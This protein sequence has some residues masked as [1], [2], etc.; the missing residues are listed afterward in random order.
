MRI[1]DIEYT[2]VINWNVAG[3]TSELETVNFALGIQIR[4]ILVR[5]QCSIKTVGVTTLDWGVWMENGESVGAGSTSA[6]MLTDSRLFPLL[7]Q[8][9]SISTNGMSVTGPYPHETNWWKLM[10]PTVQVFAIGAA[11]GDD[12]ACVLHYRFAELTSDEIIEIAA[13]R[14][15]F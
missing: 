7:F 15:Q 2:R 4:P 8:R 13:Q 14:A 11:I 9:Q 3:T 1:S 10:L 6:A 12:I 5:A